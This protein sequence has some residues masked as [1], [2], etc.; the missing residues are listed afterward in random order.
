MRREFR[1]A[2]LLAAVLIG[3]GQ[4][5]WAGSQEGTDGKAKDS[6]P[7]FK[8]ADENGNGKLSLEEAKAVGI[9]KKTF[10]EED[11]DGDGSLTK[12]DYKYGVK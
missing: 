2:V 4:V 9:S 8:E 1:L 11:L 10:E 3:F 6:L 5:A 12:Y 7:S